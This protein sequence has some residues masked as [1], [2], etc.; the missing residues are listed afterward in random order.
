MEGTPKQGDLGAC[1]QPESRR[2]QAHFVGA[3]AL[4]F[5]A[6]IATAPQASAASNGGYDALG[7]AIEY[8]ESNGF[9]PP[10]DV[11][12]EDA[13]LGGLGD[14]GG[15]LARTN[16]AT[17]QVDVGAVLD[18]I[19]AHGG[20]SP[21]ACTV[22]LARVLWHEYHHTGV[23]GGPVSPSGVPYGNWCDH[24]LL[25]RL[26]ILLLCEDIAEVEDPVARAVLCSIHESWVEEWNELRDAFNNACAGTHPQ[27]SRLMPCEECAS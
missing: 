15:P 27:Q 8:L 16:G 24:A 11:D 7:A 9:P 22:L 14:R 26:D 19:N 25:A 3:A 23:Y 5:L 13:G 10:P 20:P 2:W 4:M 12:I 1:A 18:T 6:W 17:I 21:E